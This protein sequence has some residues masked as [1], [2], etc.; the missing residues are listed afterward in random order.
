ML[1]QVVKYATIAMG[2]VALSFI[3]GC[4]S[5]INGVS[6]NLTFNSDPEGA[7]VMIDGLEM[8]VTPV[9]LEL[10]KNK[11]SNVLFRKEGYKTISV[12]LKKEFD[13]VAIIDIFWDLSTTDFLTG[14]IYQ[15]APE[16]YMVTMQPAN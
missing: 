11:Y 6:Q 4:A 2:L 9:S 15:Y 5:V 10:P 14:A 16:Q 12:P 3:S 7:S 8:G 1:N 13:A